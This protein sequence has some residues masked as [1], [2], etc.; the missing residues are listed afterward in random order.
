MTRAVG[1]GL[2]NLIVTY[3]KRNLDKH[4]PLSREN[5][6]KGGIQPNNNIEEK[7]RENVCQAPG[8]DND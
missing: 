6:I 3:T 7:W 5:N 1:V 2:H 4:K 8:H